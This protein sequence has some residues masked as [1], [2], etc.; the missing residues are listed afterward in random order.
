MNNFEE[1][2]YP[3]LS[4]KP[5]L[6]KNGV[7]FFAEENP[8]QSRDDSLRI[9]IKN[10]IPWFYNLATY[11]INFFSSVGNF[12][13][14]KA[15]EFVFG[16]EELKKKIILNLG[17]GTKDYG[18][19]IIN[20]DLF[21]FENVHIVSDVSNLPLKDQVADMVICASLMEHVKEPLSVAK[22]I[23]RVTKKGGF[24]YISVPF[25]Y[26]F[27]SSPHDYTRYTMEGLKFLFSPEFDMLKGGT[28]AG[29][30]TAILIETAYILALTLSFGS[31]KLYEFLVN[32]FIVLLSPF[33]LA[34]LLFK[35]HKKSVESAATIYFLGR[36][37]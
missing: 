35:F 8:K 27:H 20:I 10:K 36:K 24:V 21:P 4:K 26:P 28:E 37:K 12:G 16:S 15:L 32:L 6:K 13:E 9:L 7:M 18:N 14:K 1:K 5:I 31:D 3:L 33:R 23:K 34:D 11:S 17:S 22:E 30:I 29:P 25:V 2:I 19:E